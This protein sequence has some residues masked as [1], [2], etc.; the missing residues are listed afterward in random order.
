MHNRRPKGFRRRFAVFIFYSLWGILWLGWSLPALAFSLT[1]LD[2]LGELDTEQEWLVQAIQI[3]GNSVFSES[4]IQE[5]LL[6]QERPWY[7]PWKERPVFDPITFE[8]DLERLQRLYEKHGYY[9]AQIDYDLQV[10]QE[11]LLAVHFQVTANEPVE[12]VAVNVTVSAPQPGQAKHRDTPP[13]LPTET[14]PVQSGAY[15]R[16]K[17]ATDSRVKLGQRFHAK[18]GQAFH[19]KLG[20]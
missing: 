7:T 14:T 9:Q 8:T 4:E 3:S 18:V 6:T 17:W 20:H 10:E 16:P 11:G 1:E 2:E 15:S 5:A 12:I 13:P 19:G